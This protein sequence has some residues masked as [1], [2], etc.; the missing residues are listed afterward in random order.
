M[1]VGLGNDE[2]GYILPQRSW[3]EL[4]PFAYEYTK[5]PYGEVNSLG[6][7]TGPLICEAFRAL[8]ERE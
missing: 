5:A 4:P 1:L 7:R 3:D 8:A 6:P 2:V